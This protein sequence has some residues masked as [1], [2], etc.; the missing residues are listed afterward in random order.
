MFAALY[1][2]IFDARPYFSCRANM[3]GRPNW[4]PV[5]G[6]EFQRNLGALKE[7]PSGGFRGWIGE[8]SVCEVGSLS[9]KLSPEAKK[10]RKL[11]LA[12]CRFYSDGWNGA[13]FSLGAAIN[14]PGDHRGDPAFPFLALGDILNSCLS[15]RHHP[16]TVAV[17]DSAALVSRLYVMGTTKGNKASNLS[18][19][20]HAPPLAI[21]HV[22]GLQLGR[23]STRIV[24]SVD[25][26]EISF[27]FVKPRPAELL[28]IF[29]VETETSN[30]RA[31]LRLAR[32][33]FARLY[34]ELF[35]FER[36]LAI[37]LS[38]EANLLD[39]Q[40]NAALGARLNLC[41]QRLT[42]RLSPKFLREGQTYA[43]LTEIFS[44]LYRPGR[45]DELL[46]A[47]ERIGGSANLKHAVTRT[48]RSQL[49]S[50]IIEGV[51]VV[52]GN[53]YQNFG[54]AGAI[55]ENAKAE[56]FTQAWN[57]L[58]NTIDIAKLASELARLQ[59][60]MNALAKTD[61]EH[62]SANAVMEAKMATGAQEGGQ[63]MAALKKAGQWA[64]TVAEEI[65]VPVAI[66][67]L[68]VALRIPG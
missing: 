1:F 60:K 26:E 53:V 24:M 34:L 21:L 25:G 64:L 39:A 62:A 46:D 10:L 27:T 4:P 47:L 42:G 13:Q 45:L 31:S 37:L 23:N 2:P 15:S 67:V 18:A 38:P 22:R 56:N 36:G 59:A 57:S 16:T 52:N 50:E 9:I 11:R 68:K 66:E 28:P 32:A 40:G 61:S 3:I 35:C 17:R 14:S 20:S 63:V 5:H 7:R 29:I 65:A 58:P 30:G 12:F 41:A 51:V 49:A 8:N 48:L 19:V 54:Q 55:G 6:S 43:Q 44:T 33:M